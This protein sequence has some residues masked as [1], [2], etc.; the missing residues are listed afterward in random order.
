MKIFENGIL[1]SAAF[2]VNR[3]RQSSHGDSGKVVPERGND[4]GFIFSSV[5]LDA[6]LISLGEIFSVVG[7]VTKNII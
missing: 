6:V 7:L 4:D 5:A 2:I 3:E 1:P